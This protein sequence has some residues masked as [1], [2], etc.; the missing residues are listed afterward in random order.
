MSSPAGMPQGFTPQW[1]NPEP[2]APTANMNSGSNEDGVVV[3]P[4]RLKVLYTFDDQNKTNCLARWPHVLQI[5]T[6]AVDE[7]TS[8]GV[9]ELK[10]C[11]QAIVQCS[12]ELVGRLGQDYTVYA[13][14]YSE[15]EHPLV[16]QG[17]LSWALAAAST[18]PDVPAHQ[19]TK[20]VTGRV[21]K[22]IMGLF[23]NGVKE[24]LE[25][26]LRLVP[27]PT[28]M[29]SEY[30]TS[31]E[32]YREL[33]KVMPPNFDPNE[34]SA[35]LQSNPSLGQLAN[36]V[37]PTPTIH[38]N[39]REG[40]S[41]EV[42]NQLLSPSMQQQQIP[43]PLYQ[44]PNTQNTGND[45]QAENSEPAKKGSRPSSRAAVKR[46]R[47]PRQPKA[48]VAK[49]GNTSGYEEGTDGDEGPQPRKRAKTTKADW[50]SKAAIGEAPESL[51]V[52][53]STA[54][55]LRLFRPI[56]MSPVPGPGGG[57]LQEIPRAPTPV[58]RMANQHVPLDKAP[59]LSGLRRDS[60]SQGDAPRQHMSP[61]PRLEHPE[62]EPRFSIESANVSPERNQS[63]ADTPPDI[64]SSPP[65]MRTRPPSIRSSPPC[66]SSP[67]LPQ[68]PRTDSGFMSGSLEDLFGE[69]DEEP[70]HPVD[71]DTVEEAAP[72][73]SK[74]RAAEVAPHQDSGLMIE[75]ETPGPMDLLPTKM[76]IQPLK[77]VSKPRAGSVMSEDGQQSLPPL[78]RDSRVN[79]PQLSQPPQ[80]RRDSRVASPQL[81]QPIPDRQPAPQS[82][83]TSK[84]SSEP[85]PAPQQRKSQPPETQAPVQ[86]PPAQSTQPPPQP[87]SRPASRT[88]IR[89]ASM[90][91]LTL[92]TIPAS[93]PVLPHSG[94]QRSQTWSE[95]PH[96]A[97][98]APAYGQ[99][100]QHAPNSQESVHK[101]DALS[102]KESIRRK[103][104]EAIAKGETPPF[105]N[106]CGAI[107]TPS[108]RKFW[109]Q[110][111]EGDPGY[112]EYS[113][114]P[115]RVTCINILTRDDDGKPSSYKLIK[116]SLA[117]SDT[118][119]NFA[120]YLLCNPCG[121]WLSKYKTQ[122][123]AAQWTTYQPIPR[124]RTEPKPRKRHTKKPQQ[125]SGL[126]ILT[127][128]A[129][130]PQSDNN[131]PQS[132]A[133]FPQYDMPQQQSGPAGLPDGVSPTD[134]EMQRKSTEPPAGNE[135]RRST[136]SQPVKR[137]KAMTSDA[138]SAAL[139]RAIQSSPGRWQE[140]R[141][142][143]NDADDDVMGSTRR[144]LFPSPRKD[145]SPKVLGEV[146]A[147]VVQIATDVRPLNKEALIALVEATDKENCPPDFGA[148]DG[149]ADLL[150]L[151]EEELV[152]P[153]TPTR[154]S[155]ALNPF[156]T[157]TQKT[158]SH[159][160]I[161]RSVSK[162]IRSQKSPRELLFAPTPTKSSSVRRSPRHHQSVFES[163]F[164]ATL[165]QLMSEANNNQSPSRNLEIEFGSLP[166]LPNLNN[167]SADVNF[168]LE[169]F[170]STDVPMPSSPPRMFHLYE[171]PMAMQSINWNEL[172]NY[173]G[174]GH[175]NG[176]DDEIVLV[177]TEP[178]DSPQKRGEKEKESTQK[179]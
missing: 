158:P 119:A 164:T 60:Q 26:K 20:L 72:D 94:L 95:V 122:R 111:H 68:M 8:I 91:S 47:K 117:P 104:E 39:Q 90:G 25:V 87:R 128:D 129:N 17:M 15:Y 131:F 92:P 84:G 51:R 178:E 21:C 4:M 81:S 105:C 177:K 67:V 31:M 62:D 64:G 54:G 38:T 135:R 37:T 170:F 19:S 63:P 133:Y 166:D 23:A 61:Y 153:S 97:S 123:P 56:A 76:N 45:S 75:E 144:L 136:S 30:I 13:Y 2:H 115:G 138:A 163:P 114:N 168:N 5:Q 53:A 161:T 52:A 79:S 100:P 152:R 33:S 145:G 3:K 101:G 140:N 139:R 46:P 69:D 162:S 59:L 143:P 77:P 149:D 44:P 80:Q 14:D 83:P 120:T 124:S 57:H 173:R 96:P 150:K 125:N 147:N 73:F 86:Q 109:C 103:L 167:N 74:Y 35:F 112:H 107:E 41:M 106:N 88:M 50:K 113:D 146:M 159:R 22:N 32:K 27:V 6:V 48:T 66:P 12:P 11:I 28:L 99:I 110:D 98:E 65:V 102:K 171:D 132:E 108:W 70:M 165:N 71:D 156:K 169:D 78:R 179:E 89:T 176:E 42:F 1:T 85:S 29:Q 126:M 43:G 155:P 18:I 49:G 121:I 58:P 9:I 148:E 118:T 134:T 55:S 174:N 7:T 82:R 34:W 127:S 137:L 142:N 157:P 10:T 24:T 172:S 93:D 16:G 151:F 130:F 154:T 40:S 36:K 175:T 116:K 160:P 141:N